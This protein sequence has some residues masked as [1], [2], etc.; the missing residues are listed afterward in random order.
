MKK[1]IFLYLIL[2]TLLV[3]CGS[4]KG[5]LDRNNADKSLQDA[6]KRLNKN[7]DDEKA[8]EAVPELYTLIQKKH[9]D[10][11]AAYKMSSQANK[12]E[13]IVSEYEMLQSAYNGIMNSPAA[14]KK[15]NPESYAVNLVEARD[16]GAANYYGVAE[17]YFSRPG[18]DNAKFAYNNYKKVGNFVK[19]YKDINE[20][21]QQC[22]EKAIVNVVIN[23]VQDNSFFVNNGWGNY[24]M[25]YSNEFFQQKLVAELGNNNMYP[26]R[27]YNQWDARRMNVNPDWTV[28]F[29]LKNIIVPNPQSTYFSRPVSKQLQIGTDTAGRPVYNT[30]TATMNIVKTSYI[31]RMN[32]EVSVTENITR[33]VL[34]YRNFNEEFKNEQESAT[35]SGDRRALSD[36]DWELINRSGYGAPKKDEI[37]NELYKKIYPQVVAQIRVAA[38]W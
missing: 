3:S 25:N 19:G 18:R 34:S 2:G 7:P 14:F 9:L 24:G 28:N 27:Y 11:I 17:S 4:K 15:V 26:A 1:T 32:M 16:S 5:Y 13:N 10:Q 38:S 23:P 22:Y 20:K 8:L 21:M 37:L 29:I 6:V 33:K 12:W 36:S 31:S 35:F 30:V